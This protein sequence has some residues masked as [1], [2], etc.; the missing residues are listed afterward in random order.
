M[1]PPERPPPPPPLPPTPP[2]TT[3]PPAIG[4]RHSHCPEAMASP[5]ASVLVY[6]ECSDAGAGRGAKIREGPPPRPPAARRRRVWF[7]A[8]NN[9]A[10]KNKMTPTRWRGTF[11]GRGARPIHQPRCSSYR[12][13]SGFH[14]H[15][16]SSTGQGVRV[17]TTL[18]TAADGF[19]GLNC[20][21]SL[22]SIQYTT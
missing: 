4:V 14:R 10:S 18:R 2:P 3:R 22:A 6:V 17:R 11:S 8:A 19:M 1:V 12:P 15:V 9:W 7:A 21:P 16:G 5:R 20:I 13:L